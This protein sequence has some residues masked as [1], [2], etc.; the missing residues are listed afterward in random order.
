MWFLSVSLPLFLLFGICWVCACCRWVKTAFIKPFLTPSSSSALT[1]LVI[2]Q[3]LRILSSV[4]FVSLFDYLVSFLPRLSNWSLLSDLLLLHLTL[5]SFNLLLR[6]LLFDNLTLSSCFQILPSSSRHIKH[7]YSAKKF[8]YSNSNS[9]QHLATIPWILKLCWLIKSCLF[10]EFRDNLCFLQLGS[11]G[12]HW[13]SA[14]VQYTHFN[15]NRIRELSQRSRSPHT[16]K[17]MSKTHLKWQLGAAWC[18]HSPVPLPAD[19]FKKPFVH[20]SPK[21]GFLGLQTFCPNPSNAQI[22]CVHFWYPNTDL[23]RTFACVSEYSSTVCSPGDGSLYL[24]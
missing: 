1:F 2:Q 11:W 4:P 3:N 6:R 16:T 18:G 19:S 5:I 13:R 8:C 15:T 7:I 14:Y 20:N 12:Q 23:H 24:T 9:F 22:L 21:R 10:S 17:W